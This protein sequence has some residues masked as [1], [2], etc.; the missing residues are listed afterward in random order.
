LA[1]NPEAQTMSNIFDSNGRI[2]TG[3]DPQTIPED[4]RS[5][6]RAL[7]VAHIASEAAEAAEKIADRKVADCVRVHDA[8]LARVPRQSAV[9]LVKEALGL[10]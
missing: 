8:A 7:V 6:Y 10:T 2:N 3:I 4:R 5:Q 9:A 1:N